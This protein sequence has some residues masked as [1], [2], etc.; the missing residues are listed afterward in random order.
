MQ[1]AESTKASCTRWSSLLS[2]LVWEAPHLEVS[3]AACSARLLAA[4]AAEA[5]S[6][7]PDLRLMRGTALMA[8]PLALALV[9]LAVARAASWAA[10]ALRTSCSRP[11]VLQVSQNHRS[12]R[13][14]VAS[15]CCPPSTSP[16]CGTG[17]RQPCRQSQ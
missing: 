6:A 14:A 1:P 17:A 7:A 15:G 3:T 8:L 11:A 16:G 5:G 10:L 2:S 9:G 12:C 13:A 4:E